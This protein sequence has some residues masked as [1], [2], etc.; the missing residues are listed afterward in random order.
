MCEL[1]EID[2]NSYVADICCGSSSFLVTAMNQMFKKT[3]D[4]RKS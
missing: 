2:E 4:I 3:H 1:A